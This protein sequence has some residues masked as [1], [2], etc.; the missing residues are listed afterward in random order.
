MHF[1]SHV[2]GARPMDSWIQEWLDVRTSGI[3]N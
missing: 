1:R 2:T 3:C